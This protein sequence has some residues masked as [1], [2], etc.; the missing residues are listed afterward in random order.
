MQDTGIKTINHNLL[1]KIKKFFSQFYENEIK[2]IIIYDYNYNGK[3][4]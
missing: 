2:I 1:W 4:T 3:N